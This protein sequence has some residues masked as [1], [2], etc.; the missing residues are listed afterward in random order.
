MRISA[1]NTPRPPR[2]APRPQ[3]R[4]QPAQK[5][6]G[7]KSKP[8][9]MKAESESGVER[10]EVIEVLERS[11]NSPLL[12]PSLPSA[13][14]ACSA[15][16]PSLGPRYKRPRCAQRASISTN[17][18][19]T[20][21]ATSGASSNSNSCWS[22][23][24]TSMFSRS[25]AFWN[26]K[27]S[28]TLA[29]ESAKWR[30][31]LL[32]FLVYLDVWNIRGV[33]ERKVIFDAR[34]GIGEAAP[35]APPGCNTGAPARLRVAQIIP[36]APASACPPRLI[37]HLDLPPLFQ[38]TQY[39]HPRH[40]CPSPHETANIAED[41]RPRARC[42]GSK[43][44]GISR[45]GWRLG[46]EDP[47]G[48]GAVPHSRTPALELSTGRWFLAIYHHPLLDSPAA[49]TSPLLTAVVATTPYL[50]HPP[51]TPT[52]AS[53]LRSPPVAAALMYQLWAV[54]T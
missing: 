43:G 50:S 28:S 17:T 20:S 34:G 4:P 39:R 5:R 16:P 22:S 25:A 30:P 13:R 7:T 3:R 32:V 19:S 11:R 53:S 15:H 12:S 47:G 54:A 49:A 10:S 36:A 6:E 51:S 44:S 41:T 27:S 40:I 52:P 46:K 8:T 48:P 26:A 42:Q 29:A 2:R 38:P 9:K 35:S 33:F 37:N 14:T 31:Q 45:G 24:S 1:E 21:A 18:L 23:L